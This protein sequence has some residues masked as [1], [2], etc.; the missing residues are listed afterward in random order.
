M[1]TK[2]VVIFFGILSFF[3]PSNGEC[4][5]YY[6]FTD[7][8]FASDMSGNQNDLTLTE[9]NGGYVEIDQAPGPFG[10]DNTSMLLVNGR[11]MKAGSSI[12]DFAS[13]FSIGMKVKADS[14]GPIIENIR[15]TPEYIPRGLFIAVNPTT[16]TIKISFPSGENAVTDVNCSSSSWV[17]IWAVYQVSPKL[18]TVYCDGVDVYQ[19]TFSKADYNSA[20]GTA[21][22][23]G[24]SFGC[25]EIIE[26]YNCVDSNLACYGFFND[27]LNETERNSFSKI[28]ES[29]PRTAPST[30]VPL[31]PGIQ[32][33]TYI[34]DLSLP[35][36]SYSCELFQHVLLYFFNCFY[37]FISWSS[38]GIYGK[39]FSRENVGNYARRNFN[40]W[41][42]SIWRHLQHKCNA[43]KQ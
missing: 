34:E 39:C 16:S 23:F 43:I 42:I 19:A 27:V 17:T 12:V 31:P 3:H 8:S 35:I 13:D 9:R 18:V 21:N 30:L 10:I 22:N 15:F 24:W 20:M 41:W 11:G 33:Y 37:R 26:D 1:L 2:I 38:L 40:R 29:A 36:G 4:T 14:F 28:C 6:P 7:L 32:G 25:R 5:G